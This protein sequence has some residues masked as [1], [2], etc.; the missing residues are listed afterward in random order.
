MALILIVDDNSDNRYMLEVL[1][2]KNGFKTVSAVNGKE[3][4]EEARK[5]PP[6]LVVSDILMPVMDGFT[7]CKELKSDERLRGIPFVFYT[8][9]YTEPRDI[10]LGLSLGAKKFLIKPLET[11]ALLEELIQVLSEDG[12]V[13]AA[14][15]EH[16]PEEETEL[17]KQYN[18]TLF[19]KLQK[20]VGDLEMAN[21]TLQEE[22]K[23]RLLTETS[24][25]QSETHLKLLLNS[26]PVGLAWADTEDSVQYVNEKFTELFGYTVE[27]IP[28]V[29][30]WF[31][32]AF[33]DKTISKTFL[34]NWAEIGTSRKTGG[35][36][37]PFDVR[38]TCKNREI[39]DISVIGAVIG[40]LRLAIFTDITEHKRLEEQLTQAQK[41]ESI[42]NLAGGIAHDFNNILT[43]IT[44]FA[45]LLQMKMD[46]SDPLLSHVK[47]LASAGMRGAALTNQLLAFS[48]KQMLDMKTVDLNTTIVNLEK[49]LR[50]LI[51]EDIT[52]SFNVAASPFWVMADA[53]QMEQVVINLV[54]NARDA[55]P[56]G[57]SLAISTET[58]SIDDA[59]VRQ[60]GE[61]EVGEYAAIVIRD[62]G[63]GME[64]EI[65][66]KIFE[67]FFTTKEIGKGTGLGLSV[68][69]GIIRQ[70][71]GMIYVD[72]EPDKGTVFSV[73]LPMLKED[74][75]I[76]KQPVKE[77][78]SKRGSETVLMAEDN[79]VLRKMT[80][81]VLES[82]GYKVVSAEDGETALAV[83][84]EHKETIDLV[85]LDL[86]MPGKRGFDVYCEI[87]KEAPQ[88][89]VLFVTGYSEDEVEHGE[90]RARA[91]PLLSKPY[92]PFE[93]L[94]H[95]R[96]TL[97][98][99]DG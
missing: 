38:V 13:D 72:S 55:M 19:R 32:L 81:D 41:L 59:F 40:N 75:D 34:S 9:T 70:H 51:R 58:V 49:M 94:R 71:K 37:T 10:D 77:A 67:P 1:L 23:K 28:T 79:E 15:P 14:S 18:E 52:L 60:H 22:I 91:L 6:D 54:T 16:P 73:Y 53:N 39:R 56:N 61:G 63:I 57:G 78:K 5:A 87:V 4:L 25:R 26:L 27:D 12:I 99:T 3:A 80:K 64:A 21:R 97:D 95:V 24:L 48:R 8:A 11:Q 85:I 7:L 30:D 88:V 46:S 93:F 31:P 68:V 43:T 96:E 20:K 89:K 50:R 82:H 98:S 45:G 65:K 35:P 29:R 90:I 86:M 2:Q 62:D 66:R 36:T 42:G 47:E 69:Y 17:L 33:P 92:T 44:G 83:F 76:E 74:T 84:R